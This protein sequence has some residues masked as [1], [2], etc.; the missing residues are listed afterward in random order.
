MG[1]WN[2]HKR[3]EA[4]NTTYMESEYHLSSIFTTDRKSTNAV[5]LFVHRTDIVNHSAINDG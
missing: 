4:F 3:N 2:A 5:A 1:T